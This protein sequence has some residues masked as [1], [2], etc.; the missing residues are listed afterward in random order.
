MDA[1]KTFKM[2]KENIREN[3]D[4][5]KK[6]MERKV[7][8]SSP[9]DIMEKLNDLSTLLALNAEIIAQTSRIYNEKL[10]VTLRSFKDFSA[11]DKKILLAGQCSDEI[12]LMEL[13]LQINKDAHY[14]CEALRTMLSYLKEEMRNIK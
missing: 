10:S 5:I 9:S 11:T 1:E 13:A 12:Y 2:T 4:T 6:V 8:I 7:D 3:I 14:N